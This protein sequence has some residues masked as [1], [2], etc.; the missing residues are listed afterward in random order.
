MFVQSLHQ[1]RQLVTAGVQVL[2]HRLRSWTKPPRTSRILGSIHD[3]ARSKSHLVI[4]NALLRQHLIVL[5]RSVK[6]PR[7]TRTDRVLVILLVSR[8]QRWREALLMVKP[9]TLLHW[10][11]VGFRLFC[12]EAEIADQCTSAQARS[13]DDD[14][15]Q[16]DGLC[17]LPASS[18]PM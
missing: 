9:E 8:L 16:G 2:Q 12:L 17:W 15:D 3:L 11:R 7:I 13:R 5:N 18:G 6:R 1:A 10:H 14:P 4:E